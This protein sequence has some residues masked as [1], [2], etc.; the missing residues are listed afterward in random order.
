MSASSS[1]SLI[2]DARD[3]T[4]ALDTETPMEDI[5]YDVSVK[6]MLQGQLM[7]KHTVNKK[8]W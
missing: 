3:K 6:K 1:S 4:G 2:V 5:T 7:K 8:A